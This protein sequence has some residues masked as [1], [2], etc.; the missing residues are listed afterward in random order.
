MPYDFSVLRAKIADTEEWLS[1]ELSALRGGRAAPAMLDGVQAENYGVRVPLNQMASITIEDARTIRITPW[2]TA[3]V[4]NIEKAIVVADLGLSTA[5]DEKGVRAIFPELTEE[6]RREIVKIVKG[7]HEQARIAL[8]GERDE[9][10]SDIQKKEKN[11][12]I[13]EDDK[14]SFKEEMEKL[15]KEGNDKLQEIYERKEKEIITN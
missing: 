10:W 3:N 13:G 1:K 8:R 9:V 11:G 12:E 6:R 2:D 15:V 14:F 5:S 4:K 7:R